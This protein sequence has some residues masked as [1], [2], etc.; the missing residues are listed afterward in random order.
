M[1]NMYFN[2]GKEFIDNKDASTYW[3]QTKIASI[4][5]RLDKNGNLFMSP[6]HNV[7]PVIKKETIPALTLEGAVENKELT[8]NKKDDNDNL[9]GTKGYERVRRRHPTNNTY[10]YVYGKPVTIGDNTFYVYRE[11]AKG[12]WRIIHPSTGVDLI[13]DGSKQQ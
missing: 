2:I 8:H 12:D 10:S 5:Y 7:A 4:D 13:N 9:K 1:G 11:S 3:S 6:I